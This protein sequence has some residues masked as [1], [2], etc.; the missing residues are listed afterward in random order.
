MKPDER[1]TLPCNLKIK[2]S[3]M[4]VLTEGVT[5]LQP[6]DVI[7]SRA[8]QMLDVVG[9]G[10]M[11]L[12]GTDVQEI[13][14]NSGKPVNNN[15]D[16]VRATEAK[17]NKREGQIVVSFEIDPANASILQESADMGG[18]TF[19]EHCREVL[20]EAMYQGAFGEPPAPGTRRIFTPEQEAWFAK[21][22]GLENFSVAE[23][24]GH[25]KQLKRGKKAELVEVG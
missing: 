5:N 2:R 15:R 22:L 9:E 23:L 24:Q 18:R 14:T 10:G 21:E 1:V 19:E 12:S 8:S 3:T 25:V 20:A 7:S 16:I 4:D 17:A 13:S 6:M 11:L